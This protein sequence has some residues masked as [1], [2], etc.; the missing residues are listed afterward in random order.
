MSLSELELSNPS[1]KL[2]S[3]SN[4][5]FIRAKPQGVKMY[6]KNSF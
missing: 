5:S 6:L 2:S 4:K 3:L 1:L